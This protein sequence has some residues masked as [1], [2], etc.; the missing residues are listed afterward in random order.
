MREL[1][2]DFARWCGRLFYQQIHDHPG[3]AYRSY[4]ILPSIPCIPEGIIENRNSDKKYANDH[5][6]KV[7]A[8]LVK[9]QLELSCK[10]IV[11]NL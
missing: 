10:I 1:S 2:F 7:Y 3:E 4:R 5:V 9:L 6:E 8:F 11:K